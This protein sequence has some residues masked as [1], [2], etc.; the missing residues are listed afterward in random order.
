MQELDSSP[1]L[2]LEP[3]HLAELR[4]LLRRHAP[5]AQVWAYGSRVTGGA[6][7]CSDLDLVLRNPSDL[8]RRST[9]LADLR[10]ALQ[11]SR[12]P[13]LVDV[14]DWA[15]LP[16]HFHREIERQYVVL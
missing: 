6:H 7:E 9:G 12:L 10:E 4:E 2:F 8:T 13:M 11:D 1:A 15:D 14:F 3:S 5:H 16:E